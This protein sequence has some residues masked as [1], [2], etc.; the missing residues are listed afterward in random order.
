MCFSVKALGF[1]ADLTP[2]T[3]RT[4]CGFMGLT[5]LFRGLVRLWRYLDLHTLKRVLI[6]TMDILIPFSHDPAVL[7]SGLV[8]NTLCV[9][10][11]N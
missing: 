9:S 7:G 10:R 4:M 6:L 11:E 8:P 2:R 3:E 1:D 5:F